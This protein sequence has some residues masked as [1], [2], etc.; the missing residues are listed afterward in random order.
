V[1]FPLVLEIPAEGAGCAARCVPWHIVFGNRRWW[2]VG[3]RKERKWVQYRRWSIGSGRFV[4]RGIQ[5]RRRSPVPRCTCGRGLARLR[6]RGPSPGRRTGGRDR[7]GECHNADADTH[8]RTGVAAFRIR[9]NAA[10][11]DRVRQAKCPRVGRHRVAIEQHAAEDEGEQH[12]HSAAR[13][14]RVRGYQRHLV[15]VVAGDAG[16]SSAAYSFVVNDEKDRDGGVAPFFHQNCT[17]PLSRHPYRLLRYVH[18]CCVGIASALGNPLVPQRGIRSRPSQ[19]STSSHCARSVT[20][21]QALKGGILDPGA[22]LIGYLNGSLHAE[23]WPLLDSA[24]QVRG[25]TRTRDLEH[26]LRSAAGPPGRAGV[27][28]LRISQY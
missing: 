4:D 25:D 3:Q 10:A 28:P 6:Q 24:I 2:T 12:G 8:A 22:A 16:D 17:A 27:E 18:T 20:S 19:L 7:L 26:H 11:A 5:V 9:A 1:I 15:V 14:A 21:K 13:I 23:T